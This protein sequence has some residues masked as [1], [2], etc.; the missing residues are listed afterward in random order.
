CALRICSEPN[1]EDEL[2]EVGPEP[3]EDDTEDSITVTETA[4][5]DNFTIPWLKTMRCAAHTLQLAVW[6]FLKPKHIQAL[7]VKAR[8]LVRKLRIPSLRY[9]LKSRKL[10]I[11]QIDV[12]TRWSS[13]GIMIENLLKLEPTVKEFLDNKIIEANRLQPCFWESLKE[14]SSTLEPA[15]IATTKLQTANITA[16]EF[17][18]VWTKMKLSVRSQ[19]TGLAGLF[20]KCIENREKNL[21][22]NEGLLMSIYADP[23]YK[24]ILTVEQVSVAR[25]EILVIAER[26][27][28]L[29]ASATDIVQEGSVAD[30]DDTC[31]DHDYMY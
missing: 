31:G 18:E 7:I 16:G 17:H 4:A 26:L 28:R 2:E 9:M 21:L 23:R 8:C 14:L 3:N 12:T 1:D 19:E 29:T 15:K 20:V 10:A 5:I 25:D 30:I 13:T 24:S 11:P 27:H 6:D 22:L